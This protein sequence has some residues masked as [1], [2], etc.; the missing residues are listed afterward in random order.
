MNGILLL[1]I[2]LPGTKPFDP[3]V[4]G[5]PEDFSGAVGAFRISAKAEPKQVEV[6]K[7]FLLT[8]RIEATREAP[9]PPRRLPLNRDPY[10]TD[11]FFLEDPE[12]KERQLNAT[13][14]EF[15]YTLKPRRLDVKEVPDIKLVYFD[16]SYGQSPDGYQTLYSDPIAI[17]VIEQKATVPGVGQDRRLQAP[18][19]LFD[20]AQGEML[21]QREKPWQLPATP[22]LLILFLAPPVGC[23]LWLGLWQR[24]YPDAA[25]MA[26]RKRSRAARQALRGLSKARSLPSEQQATQVAELL[27]CYLQHRYHL[28]TREPTPKEVGSHLQRYGFSEKLI[29]Q[30]S[31]LFRQ[32]DTGRY[33][34]TEQREEALAKTAEQWVLDLEGESWSLPL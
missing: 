34:P 6:E 10:F 16:P 30:G 26:R 27:T 23:L 8:V 11:D 17:S 7:P 28:L 5:Q 33:A 20:F 22:V 3:P 24:L 12:P 29:Q 4:V 31:H 18:S 32:C 21:L 13:T 2:L 25:R 14:W 15:Y 9:A 19:S 1:L